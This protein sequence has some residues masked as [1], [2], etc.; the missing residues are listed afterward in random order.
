MS[1]RDRRKAAQQRADAL[2]SRESYVAALEEEKRGYQVR[3]LTDRAK[4]VDTE[5]AKARKALAAATPK[6]TEKPKAETR[7]EPKGRTSARAA[8]TDEAKDADEAKQDDKS[9]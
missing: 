3:G 1:S 9:S 6:T 5:L 8:V 4:A 2:S 7:P